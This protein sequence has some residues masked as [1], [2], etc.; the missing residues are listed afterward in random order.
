MDNE[1]K[2]NILKKEGIDKV[3]LTEFNEELMKLSPEGFIKK[4]CSD[5]NIKGIVVGFN[6]RFGHKNLGD[7]ELL[8]E[9]SSK[10]K[11]EVLV[12]KPMMFNESVISSTRIRK[13]LSEGG[14]M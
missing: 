5:Y 6:Y 4:L 10:Y 8:R 9:L 11:Y 3:V 7:I 13:S 14:H 12:M 2:L 1:N